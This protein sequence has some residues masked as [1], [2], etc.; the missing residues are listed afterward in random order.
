MRIRFASVYVINGRELGHEMYFLKL[1]MLE[2]MAERA[3]PDLRAEGT[4]TIIAGDFNVCPTDVDVWDPSATSGGTHVSPPSARRSRPSRS[5]PI[6]SMR[7]SSGGA[8]RRSSSP[9][10]TTAPATSTRTSACGSTCT[11]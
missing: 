5:M 7:T 10:G 11:S 2:A 3:A 6:S 8:P 4:P 9:G 1:E